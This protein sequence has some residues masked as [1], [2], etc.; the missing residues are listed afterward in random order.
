MQMNSIKFFSKWRR[1]FNTIIPTMFIA[2]LGLKDPINKDS[3]MKLNAD[4]YR[5][6]ILEGRTTQQ[7]AFGKTFLISSMSR[8]S[9][10]VLKWVKARHGSRLSAIVHFISFG[11]ENKTVINDRELTRDST[12]GN[13]FQIALRAFEGACFEVDFDDDC[14]VAQIEGID[15]FRTSFL[16]LYYSADSSANPLDVDALFPRMFFVE[17]FQRILPIPVDTTGKLFSQEFE[18]PAIPGE[19]LRTQVAI[20]PANL[21]DAEWDYNSSYSVDQIFGQNLDNQ[22]PLKGSGVGTIKLDPLTGGVRSNIY[23]I[24]ASGIFFLTSGEVELKVKCHIETQ[25]E[26]ITDPAK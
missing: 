10:F 20:R 19:P 24:D 13:P 4:G 7:S 9:C 22:V 18:R 5:F 15:G 23:D 1:L 3:M 21:N 8:S 2:Y 12:L 6:V 17:Y 11:L 16:K 14:K 25:V 26:K